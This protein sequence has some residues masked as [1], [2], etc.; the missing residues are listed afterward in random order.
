MIKKR[1]LKTYL[2]QCKL[3]PSAK[4]YCLNEL[5]D[6]FGIFKTN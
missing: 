3:S 4:L 6:E 5:V 1:E 2:N